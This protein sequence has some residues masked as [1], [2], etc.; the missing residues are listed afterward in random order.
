MREKSDSLT[1]QVKK[2]DERM[3]GA[4]N[5]TPR[6]LGAYVMF[7]NDAPGLDQELRT[8]AEKK[9]IQRVALGIGAPP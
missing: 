6:P 3:Q 7:M 4:G 9:A 8:L 5:K 2:I 1:S